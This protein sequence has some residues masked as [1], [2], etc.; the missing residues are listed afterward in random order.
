MNKI[1][2]IGE[3]EYQYVHEV[4]QDGFHT[5]VNGKMT[6]RLEEAFAGKYNVKYAI[7]L[8][9]GTATL[10]AAL[11]AAGIGNGDEV[12]VPPL[13]MASTTLAVLH[14]NAIPVFADIDPDTFEIS[15]SAIKKVIT[16]RTKAIIP[17]S[18]FGLAPDFDPILEIARQ[19]N[20]III[21]DDAQ[22]FLGR[23]KDRLVGTIGDIA[24][25]SFQSS[26]HMTSGEGG[27]LITDNEELA[28]KIRRYSG[29]GYASVSARKGRI[30]KGDI[31]DPYYSRHIAI[32]WNYRIS[33]ICSAVALGQL[34]RLD[35]LNAFRTESALRHARVLS[36][37]PWLI[38]QKFGPEYSHA[39][40]SYP[41]KIAD[42][43]LVWKDFYNYYIAAGGP[44]FYAAWKLTYREPFMQKREWAGREKY[45]PGYVDLHYPNS[46]LCPIAETIQPQLMLFKTNYWDLALLDKDMAALE[47]TVDFFDRQLH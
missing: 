11:E 41:V 7:A 33:D 36:Q 24:S 34:E 27:M 4:L 44:G 26:K 8:C 18:L 10:H 21:E 47:K 6:K 19:H 12:I 38:P 35:E 5:S 42:D 37:V 28:G 30:T 2:R 43:R 3:N 25:F 45:V 15:V 29:L 31:Q 14:A 32:G 17:V 9:N 23:Y 20:L 13:T 22:C 40:W 16:P 1:D 39:W 46:G